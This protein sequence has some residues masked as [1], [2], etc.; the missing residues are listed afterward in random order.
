MLLKHAAEYPILSEFLYMPYEAGLGA[1]VECLVYG[2]CC[3]VLYPDVV[4][5]LVV[6]IMGPGSWHLAV[7]RHIIFRG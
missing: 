5:M 7:W 6:W 1:D 3:M 4:S 2:P